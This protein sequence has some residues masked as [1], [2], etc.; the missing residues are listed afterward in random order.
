[1]FYFQKGEIADRSPA[2]SA[3]GIFEMMD[4]NNI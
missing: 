3:E 4:D 1:M 2:V